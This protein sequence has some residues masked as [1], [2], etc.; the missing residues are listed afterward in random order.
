MTSP[1]LTPYT[2]L[3]LYDRS[4]RDIVD[5]ALLDAQVKLP[6]WTPREGNTEVVLIEA[7]ALQVAE[8]VYAINR[9]PGAVMEILMQLLGV[10]RSLGAP[11]TGTVTVTVVDDT[12][13]AIAAGTAF[14]LALD[15]G[16]VVLEST[17]TVAVPP[18]S[19]SAVVDV[20]ATTYGADPNGAPAGTPLDV[21]SS[22]FYLEAAVLAA[23]LAGGAD[24]ED[25]GAWLE[26]GVQRLARLTDSLVLPEHFTARALEDVRVGRANTIDLL[27]PA[28]GPAGSD[29][30]HVTVVVADTAGAALSAG[31]MSDLEQ[32]LE[33]SATANLDVHVVAP[34]VTDVDVTATVVRLTGHDP[35]TVE[36]DVIAALDAYLD[37]G[38]WEWGATV[39]R[40]ELIALLDGVTGVDYVASI[41][42]PAADVALAGT[43]PLADLG[44][45][46]ITVDDPA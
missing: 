18:G 20:T 42:T 25:T 33:E 17:A 37:P 23:D 12:G 2:D 16:D 43:G 15:T 29:L 44:V 36:A 28:A 13:Y 3:V 27:D 5:R 4:P 7:M 24:V 40:N 1:D 14:R 22:A 8:L 21:I 45:A 32:A 31:V 39:R 6:G 19:T 9:A 10:T 26:R 35:A 46:T 34:T 41:T 30:G 11:A 38:A